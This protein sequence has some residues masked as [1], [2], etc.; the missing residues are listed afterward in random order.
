MKD[1]QLEQKV[2]D[3]FSTANF[4]V[5][6]WLGKS[7]TI[8]RFV[9]CKVCK[10]ALKKKSEVNRLI[11]NSKLGFKRK[12][13]L[14]ICENSIPYNWHLAWM[15]RELQRAKKIHNSWSNKGIIKFKRTMNEQPISVDHESEIKAFHPDFISK[16]RYRTS[17]RDTICFIKYQN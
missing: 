3:T 2:I 15:C 11:D 17:W 12:N 8:A 1:E 7:K 14:F 10:D 6:H 4:E 13:K 5:C 9:N 16:E